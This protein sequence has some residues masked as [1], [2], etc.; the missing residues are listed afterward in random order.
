MYYRQNQAVPEI[1]AALEISEDNVRKRIARGRDFLKEAVAKQIENLIEFTRPGEYFVAAVLATIPIL[2]TGQQAFAASSAGIIA[3]QSASSSGASSSG[4]TGI[5]TTC[6]SLLFSLVPFITVFLGTVFG[7]WNGIRNAPTLRSRQLML[8]VVLEYYFIFSVVYLLIELQPISIYF[9][10]IEFSS[11][12]IKEL[13]YILWIAIW[14]PLVTFN[15]IRI[16]RKWRRIVE[17]DNENHNHENKTSEWKSI[18]WLLVVSLLLNTIAIVT[19]VWRWNVYISVELNWQQWFT[20]LA[21]PVSL[22]SF[23][24]CSWRI[25]KNEISFLNAPPR[26]PNLL[27]I[28]TGE[29]ASPRGFRNRINF[30]GDITGIGQGM[31]CMQMF[32]VGWYFQ[33][34]NLPD[35][36]LFG[37]SIGNGAWFLIG[38]SALA[39]LLFAVFFAGIPRRRYWGMIFLA[40]IIFACNGVMIY[41]YRLWQYVDMKEFTIVFGLNFW[42]LIWFMLLGLAGLHV[43]RAKQ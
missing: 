27:K 40:N 21:F 22:V 26:L 42:Y 16:N 25:S 39:Y 34:S 36:T 9:M 6:Y 20:L 4:L 5:A 11:P 12:G 37:F 23:Y 28:L 14:P 35:K 13:I 7:V 43:F 30:C 19:F 2:A 33:F 18:G 32:S 10:S 41:S 29:K 31:I 24:F 17:Q 15:T 38:L 8:K 1:A 3:A